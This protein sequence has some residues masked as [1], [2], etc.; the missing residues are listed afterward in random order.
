MQIPLL[1]NVTGIITTFGGMA[2]MHLKA[3]RPI[4]NAM[5]VILIIDFFITIDFCHSKIR[6]HF[7]FHQ[8]KMQKLYHKCC[9]G[10][11]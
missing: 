5:T 4:M 9:N 6:N 11:S 1:T 10:K 2:A 8:I 7:S 3:G